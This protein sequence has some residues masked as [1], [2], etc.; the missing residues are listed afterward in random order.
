MSATAKKHP[1]PAPSQAR[2]SILDAERRQIEKL[3]ETLR[4]G[5]AKLVDPGGEAKVPPDSLP[6]FLTE[7]IQA[8]NQGKP[9]YIVQNQAAL[10]TI[11]AAAML[12]VSRQFLVN[13]LKKGEIAHHKVGTHRRIY[14]RDLLQYKR[15]RDALQHSLLRKLA[16]AEVESGLYDRIPSTLGD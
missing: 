14:A 6:A 2:I 1:L 13:L 15:K 8:L 3:Y 12:G 5:G 10:T 11:E 9:V 4:A 7:M 16:K